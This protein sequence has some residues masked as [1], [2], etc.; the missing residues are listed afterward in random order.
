MSGNPDVL[1]EINDDD[2]NL[3]L[4]Q[5][6]Q[7][8]RIVSEVSTFRPFQLRDRR[9]DTKKQTFDKDIETMMIDQSVDPSLCCVLRDDLRRLAN[10]FF[11]VSKSSDTS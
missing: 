9:I 8:H 11:S 10:I 4:W 3:C 1:F 2:F 5:R 6:N 7:D